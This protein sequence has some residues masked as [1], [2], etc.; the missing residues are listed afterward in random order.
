[1]NS[2]TPHPPEVG[3]ADKKEEGEK[4]EG[5]GNSGWLR[6]HTGSLT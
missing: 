1:M 3:H 6:L 5:E 2:V 4:E